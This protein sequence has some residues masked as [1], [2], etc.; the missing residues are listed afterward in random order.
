MIFYRNFKR[1][2][3]TRV[4]LMEDWDIITTTAEQMGN[5]TFGDVTRGSAW[6]SPMV[7]GAIPG[8]C[9]VK[10][11]QYNWYIAFY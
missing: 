4:G 8:Y 7:Y 5:D 2:T 9:T 10:T 3:R 1:G 6:S 11:K